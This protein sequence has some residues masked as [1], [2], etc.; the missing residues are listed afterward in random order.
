ML[1]EPLDTVPSR[2]RGHGFTRARST[3]GR[4]CGGRLVRVHGETAVEH[5][6]KE[7]I[8]TITLEDVLNRWSDESSRAVDAM[9]CVWNAPTGFAAENRDGRSQAAEVLPEMLDRL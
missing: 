5:G 7:R 2:E 9:D 8:S 4:R 6:E 1:E 3:G